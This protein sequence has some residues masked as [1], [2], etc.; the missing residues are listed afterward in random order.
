MAAKVIIHAGLGAALSVTAIV[1]NLA[2]AI[3][4]LTSAGVPLSSPGALAPVVA[5]SVVSA[6]LFGAA[7]VGLGALLANQTAAIAVSLVW[8]L[9]VEGVVINILTAPGLRDWLPGGALATVA[10]GSGGPHLW[11]AAGCALIYTVGLVTTGT[12]RLAR[13]DVT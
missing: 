8:L 10:H 2:V 12:L 6:A 5:G 11:A 3:P 7:G 1:V 4:W 9:A 13:R